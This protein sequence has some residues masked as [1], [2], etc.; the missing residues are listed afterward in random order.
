MDKINNIIDIILSE[1]Q[2]EA[3]QILLKVD[4]S[5]AKSK[6]ENDAEIEMIKL[7]AEGEIATEKEAISLKTESLIE[8]RSRQQRLAQRQQLISEVIE[9]ALKKF[10]DLS[11]Q[12]KVEL[13]AKTIRSR[14]VEAG[15]ICLNRNEQ[16]LLK[17]LLSG[18]NSNFVAGEIVDI[19][20]G[21]IIKHNRIEENLSLDLIIRDNRPSL[22]VIVAGVLFPEDK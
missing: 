3:D 15:E 16:E 17:P 18:L 19:S 11:D 8:T 9:L 22:S 1:A 12:S 4:Q 7:L 5:I 13:Y 2:N 6:S 10:D 14:G 20:G 21:L